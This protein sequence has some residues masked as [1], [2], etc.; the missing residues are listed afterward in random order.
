MA[1]YT[2]YLKDSVTGNDSE[3]PARNLSEV[4]ETILQFIGWSVAAERFVKQHMILG[5][6]ATTIT[7]HTVRYELS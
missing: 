2:V 5:C 7:G 4:R 1:K 3:I 6:E